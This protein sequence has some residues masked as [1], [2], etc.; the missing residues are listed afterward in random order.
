MNNIQSKSRCRRH[1][2]AISNKRQRG[3]AIITALLIVTI[4]VVVSI[5]ISTRLQLDVRRTGNLVAQDQARFYLFAAEEWAQRILRDDSKDNSVDDLSEAW[6]FELPPLPVAGGSIQG[7]LTDLNSCININLLM[8][9]TPASNSSADPATPASTIDPTVE[10]RLKQ[11][12][13]NL[14]VDTNLTQGIAD[15]IDKDLNTTSPDG[16]ED[17]YYLNLEHPYHTANLPLQSITELRLIKGFED[18]EVYNMVK[19]YLCPFI[20]LGTPV[21]INVNTASAEVLKSLSPTMTDSLVKNI[22]EERDDDAFKDIKQFTSFNKLDTI[23]KDTA[24]LSTQSDYFLLRSQA[25]I[26]QAN[27]V[28]YSVIHRESSGKSQVI[29][30]VYRTL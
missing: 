9:G 20:P 1:Q 26:G 24:M 22:I 21:N 15:W 16:A 30:R 11:L 19:D 6:A 7:K 3:V 29:S 28:M 12:F 23:I 2:P 27:M 25:I 5:N 13:R 17:G 8:A 14:G 18:A 10:T 4:A